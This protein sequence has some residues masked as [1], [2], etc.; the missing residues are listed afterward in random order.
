MRQLALPNRANGA[1]IS[2]RAGR[3]TA[4]AIENLQPRGVLF[5]APGEEVYEGMVVGEHNRTNDLDVNITREKK[6]TNMRA[7]GSDDT[8]RL[9]PPLVMNLEQALEFIREDELVEVTPNTFRIRKRILPA[10]RRK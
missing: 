3:T 2:D 1:L 8:V 10:N 4:H 9:V 7:S 5:V 6:L